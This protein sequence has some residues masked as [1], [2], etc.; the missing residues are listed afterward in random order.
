M[1]KH[2]DNKLAALGPRPHRV[3]S[4]PQ[5]QGPGG[6]LKLIKGHRASQRSSLAGWKVL[7][8]DDDRDVHATV[9][10]ALGDVV[11]ENRPL[12]LLFAESGAQ[13]LKILADS[14]DIALVLLDVVMESEQSGLELV[15]E[16]RDHLGNR[17]IQIAIVT[18]QPAY[19][20]EQMVVEQYQINDYRLKT[21]LSADKLT[22][23]VCSAIRSYKLLCELTDSQ[24]R[25]KHTAVACMEA[26]QRY[27]DLYDHAPDMYFSVAADSARITQCNRTLVE[28]LGYDGKEELIGR[29][30]FDLYQSE[31]QERMREA[32]ENFIETGEVHD[33]ELRLRRKDGS[34][35]DV[36]LNVTAERDA[37][38]AILQGRSSLRDIAERKKA[39]V[40]LVASEERS[41]LLLES[42]GDG[43][44]GV[45]LQGHCT[46]INPAAL[47]MLG[48]H[49]EDLL[50]REVHSII[51]QRFPDERE[52]PL[53]E[54][55]MNQSLCGKTGVRKEEEVLWH[56]DGS[57]IYVEYCS[58][59]IQKDE[60]VLGA[61]VIVHD[62]TARMRAEQKIKHLAFHDSLTGL[63]NRALFTQHLNHALA[64]L[65]RESIGFALL[66]MDLDNFKDVN[67]TLGHP[68]G[69]ILLRAVAER[70]G[71]IVRDTDTFARFGGDEFALLQTHVCDYAD[72]SILAAKIIEQ[73]K[74]EFVLDG[75]SVHINAS[76]GIVLPQKE[77]CGADDMISRADVA[78]YKAKD[79][80]KGRF[81]F[82]EDA[83][84]EQ[85]Q[86]EIDL[87]QDLIRAVE[88]DEFVLEYQPQLDIWKRRLI[89]MEALVRWRH[90]TRGI[91]KPAEFLD[92]AEK[93]GLIQAISDLVL[94][95]ACRQSH[96]WAE[97][98]LDFGRIAVNLSAQQLANPDFSDNVVA[99]LDREVACPH[100]LE[101]EFTETALIEADIRTQADIIRLSE[102]GVQFAIDDFGTG[103]SSLQ[104]LTKFR[105]DKIKIDR[106]FI[107]NVENDHNDSEIV[108]ATIALGAALNLVTLAEGVETPG[109]EAFLKAHGCKQV[110]GYLYSLPVSAEQIERDWLSGE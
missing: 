73:I 8:V 16:I 50:G 24:E 3:E 88:R 83:M 103:F 43:I 32:F 95:R 57:P 100:H 31:S 33:A 71:K 59:P 80:G 75:A 56:K 11:I 28:V 96:D 47:R 25:L 99:I 17:K 69:D 107:R 27:L 14:P 77:P 90:P 98:G 70:I 23:L 72:A 60:T 78:L 49:E 55:P 79:A 101:L 39:E 19:A 6:N 1:T 42:V 61:V 104:Y 34:G 64:N 22:T 52:Y 40:A 68:S 85:L 91:L 82:F 58:V 30:V 15:R 21:D 102:L 7:V 38:G 29:P 12:A 54:C 5:R 51:H 45:D 63:P 110:Q 41:R 66:M 18:G 44:I 108:K 46:F 48:Y 62:M 74:Q 9:S 86:R 89:G 20:P 109:Q 36:S 93:R 10:L 26:E 97:R 2:T 87:A 4:G 65:N 105:A 81:A 37:E 53:S 84:N 76:I 106:E 35:L 94:S 13:A 67:D 92:V